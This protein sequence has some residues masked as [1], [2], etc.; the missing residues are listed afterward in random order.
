[1][2]TFFDFPR[3]NVRLGSQPL[4]HAQATYHKTSVLLAQPN[5]LSSFFLQTFDKQGFYRDESKTYHEEMEEL[6]KPTLSG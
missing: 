2:L 3:F 6:A 4:L 5:I 1:V